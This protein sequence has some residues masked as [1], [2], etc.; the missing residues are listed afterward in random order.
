MKVDTP[1]NVY[2]EAPAGSVIGA[3]RP[4]IRL[5]GRR[6]GPLDDARPHLLSGVAG[7]RRWLTKNL[8]KRQNFLPRSGCA[9]P[10]ARR[11]IH[12]R[13]QEQSTRVR[14]AGGSHAVD[15]WCSVRRPI[16]GRL[17]AVLRTG[18]AVARRLSARPI[19]SV[20]GR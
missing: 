6:T 19:T 10:L 18:G 11:S 16:T 8:S 4:T 14:H 17:S 5:V 15:A 2:A 1:G 12:P 7:A 13:Q 9:W 3:R 20:I